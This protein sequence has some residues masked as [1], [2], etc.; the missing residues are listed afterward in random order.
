M[1]IAASPIASLPIAGRVVTASGGAYTLTCLTGVYNLAGQSA[2]LR[3]S[4][5]LT[6][7]VG[8]YSLN[9]Q[10]AILR[11]SRV[12]IA[13][14]GA[15]ATAG[16]QATLTKSKLVTALAGV[17]NLNGQNAVLTYTPTG[18]VYTLTCLTGSYSLNGQNATL[19]KSKSL[20]AQTG[21]YTLN[22]QSANLARGRNLTAQTGV[23]SLNGQS[24]TLTKTSAGVYTL[25]C[26]T[27]VYSLTGSS[28]VLTKSGSAQ[29]Q[30][31]GGISK[32]SRLFIIEVD[33]TEYRVPQN[34]LESFLEAIPKKVEEKKVQ[35][36]APTKRFKPVDIEIVSAPI[37]FIEKLKTAPIYAS[38]RA[39][40]QFI[41]AAI[42]YQQELDDEE[43]ILLLM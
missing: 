39:N 22:G 14:T 21:A 35:R 12:L 20:V 9:G 36:K 4:K 10:Q 23:Y 2:T 43:A 29:N 17:Y 8:A 1:S 18:T 5:L 6:A 38:L 28:A 16:Q 33:G 34:K 30:V 11:K 31:A 25:T 41:N 7:Q 26:L 24:A 40:E 19:L 42:R 3:K 32:K 15:Y 37:A 27:G 13:Q